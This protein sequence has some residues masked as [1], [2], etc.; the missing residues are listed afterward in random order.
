MLAFISEG[1]MS[2]F[3]NER[4]TTLDSLTAEK[5]RQ[6]VNEINRDERGRLLRLL[7]HLTL[8]VTGTE[9]FDQ[10]VVTRGGVNVKEINPSTMESKLVKGL[11]FAGEVID[12]DG[13]TGGFNL[14]IAFAT[15]ACAGRSI[16]RG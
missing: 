3:E 4:I 7:K 15:G 10:A 14:Q 9:G 6:K 11:Y 16:N 5:Y 8:T 13:L 12:V 1:K 2:F